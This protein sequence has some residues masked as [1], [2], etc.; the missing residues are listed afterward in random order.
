MQPENQ[1]SLSMLNKWNWGAFFLT[2]F[3]LLRNGFWITLILFIAF[4]IFFPIGALLISFL[5]L[6]KGNSWSWNNGKRWNDIEEFADS[7]YFW[8]FLGLVIAAFLLLAL[9]LYPNEVLALFG[10]T[11]DTFIPSTQ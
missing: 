3:W 5:F 11:N 7:Q 4:R 2:P 9:V 8:N 10:L 6:I 1:V